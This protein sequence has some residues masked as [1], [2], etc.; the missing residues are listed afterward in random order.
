M[1]P[2]DKRPEGRGRLRQ[3]LATGLVASG[4]PIAGLIGPPKKGEALG[5][6]LLVFAGV[7]LLSLSVLAYLALRAPDGFEDEDGFH[8]GK[9]RQD[10]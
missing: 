9:P 5:V 2:Q 3:D 8:L 6:G 7:V 1:Q 4:I 10:A